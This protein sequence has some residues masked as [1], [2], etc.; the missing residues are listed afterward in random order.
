MKDTII[1]FNVLNKKYFILL[2]ILCSHWFM[3]MHEIMDFIYYI[4]CIIAL[5]LNP[6]M[7]NYD[8]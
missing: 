1:D 3:T 4:I 5:V 7:F 8:R 2:D 6:N